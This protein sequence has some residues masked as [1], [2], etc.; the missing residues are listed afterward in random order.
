M[1]SFAGEL[2]VA[3]VILWEL[4][5]NRR[6]NFLTQAASQDM[7]EGRAEIY[8]EFMSFGGDGPAKSEEL[9][10]LMWRSSVFKKKC[11]AHILLF[12]TLGGPANFAFFDRLFGLNQFVSVFPHSVVAFWYMLQPYIE[13]RQKRTGP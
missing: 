7:Y 8:D 6:V 12:E 10:K 13:E 5:E 9:R 4:D 1:L 2:I 3:G 11:D